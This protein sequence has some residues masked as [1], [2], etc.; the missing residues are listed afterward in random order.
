MLMRKRLK[1]IH[2]DWPQVSVGK[3]VSICTTEHFNYDPKA[4]LSNAPTQAH[5]VFT[6]HTAARPFVQTLSPGHKAGMLAAVTCDQ[7]RHHTR[8][9]CLVS[10]PSDHVARVPD[11]DALARNPLWSTMMKAFPSGNG[12]QDPKRADRNDSGQLASPLKYQFVHPPS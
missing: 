2:S 9:A 10:N 4:D 11:Q 12:H 1:Q 8:N 7:T 5:A 3:Q 6:C